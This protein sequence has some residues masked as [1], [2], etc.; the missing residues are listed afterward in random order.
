M[1]TQSDQSA[2]AHSP[3]FPCAQCGAKL[4]YAPGTSTLLCPYCGHRNAIDAG[5]EVGGAASALGPV[6]EL[7]FR[8]A[9]AEEQRSAPR[10]EF[11]TV[12]CVA[13]AAQTTRPPN[14]TAF[15]CPFCGTPINAT[16]LTSHLIT[17]R[18]LLPFKTTQNEA[19]DL[20]RRWLRSLWFAPTALKSQA[21]VDAAIRGVYLPY[22]TYDARTVTRYVGERG[23]AY[24]VPVTTTVM[25]NG[26]PQTRT[27][28]QRRIRWTS[29]SG[30]VE[31]GFDDLLVPA[32]RSIPNDKARVLE[33]W[34]LGSL[35]PYQDAY[36]S[37]FVAESYQIDLEGG[38]EIARAMMNPVIESTI[39]S[40]IGG[41]EQRIHDFRPAYS[42]VTFKHLLLPAWI[43]AYRYMNKVYHFFVNAR[44]G[45]VTGERPWSFWKI[46]GAVVAG[47]IAIGVVALIAYMF[48]R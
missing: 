29:V 38:F 41:D 20:F 1:N 19:R 17:P 34:D 24:Y 22:W 31:N 36:L 32:S 5:P 16:E 9:L 15:S 10:T 43:S 45:E 37:G 42:N 23:D 14:V 25:V 8:A 27:V 6:E 44:T 46:A 28:M 47:L 4:E 11:T 33:P 18:S 13:C 39:R 30:V 48:G 3:G 12:K 35:V 40:D 7:D 26:K 21:Y 2:T